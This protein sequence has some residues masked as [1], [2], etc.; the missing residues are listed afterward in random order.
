MMVKIVRRTP[1]ALEFESLLVSVGFRGHDPASTELAL[2]NTLFCICAMD[3]KE[4]IG[5]GRIVGDGAISLLLTN[6]MVRPSYQRRGIGTRI[7]RELL[8]CVEELPHRNIVLEVAPLPGS[9]EFYESLDFK[10]SR[11]APPG[12][13]KWFHTSA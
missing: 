13:V 7:V 4:V 3:E 1:T 8:S 9:Q 10:S 6:I 2:A 5:L 12:M 11:G